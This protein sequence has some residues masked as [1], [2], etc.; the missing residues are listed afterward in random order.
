MPGPSAKPVRFPSGTS[1]DFPWQ[2]LADFGFRNPFMYHEWEDDFDTLNTLYTATKTSAG[3]IAS[4]AGDGGRVLF[5]TNA[6][7]PLVGDICSL[8][9]PVAGFAPAANKKQF[10]MT[11]V[12]LADVT[13]PALL[14]GLI[15]TTA[16]PFTVTDGIY[17]SKATG[18]AANLQLISMVGSVPTTLTIATANYTLTNGADLDLGFYINR[19]RTIYA[20]V[21]PALVGWF[22]QSGGLANSKGPVGSIVNPT[23]TAVNLNPT[24]AIQS[25]TASSKTM[26]LDFAM[27][28]KER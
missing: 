9:L 27:A 2:P 20:F 16:T 10:F 22:T 7:T 21:G 13:N 26:T 8:Q 6:S 12:N 23:L 18:S 17:F 1:T 25:G 24:I 19:N 4:A 5:T 15:Q 11:R 14:V 28:A 3:T